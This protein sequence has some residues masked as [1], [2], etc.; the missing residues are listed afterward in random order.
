MENLNN[1]TRRQAIVE[2][3]FGTIK[4][5]YDS[6]NML[7]KGF[8]SVSA[9]IG[10]IYCAYNLKRVSNIL[11]VREMVRRLRELCFCYSTKIQLLVR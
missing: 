5:R 11:G 8:E 3:P 9:E 7:T 4:R 2:H 1:Y 10:L 6:Y